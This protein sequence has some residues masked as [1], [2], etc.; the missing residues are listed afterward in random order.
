M[1][2][3]TRLVLCLSLLLAL[4][5]HAP[6]Q[7]D[8]LKGV[9][10]VTLTL[11]IDKTLVGAGVDES[12]VRNSVELKLKN[13]GLVILP[14]FPKQGEAHAKTCVALVMSADGMRIEGNNLYCYSCRSEVEEYT[15]TLRSPPA[16]VVSTTWSESNFGCV[17]TSRVDEIR[18]VIDDL[19]NSFC[20]A[21][22]T[23]NPK[24]SPVAP[25]P[26]PTSPP[27]APQTQPVH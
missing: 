20:N 10:A 22:L 3:G 15:L 27:A 4:L 16:Y 5:V 26:T 11:T 24:P 9:T 21:Y 23:A 18:R 8:A 14:L 19:T 25:D 1:I 6:A 13:T 2:N 7:A 17:G 12:S